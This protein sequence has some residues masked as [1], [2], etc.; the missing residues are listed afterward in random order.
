LI[1]LTE[2]FEEL[3][4]LLTGVVLHS[5]WIIGSPQ[6]I[7]DM[8]CLKI[9]IDGREDRTSTS[10]AKKSQSYRDATAPVTGKAIM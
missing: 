7:A 2:V 8:E 4:I 6:R 3:L 10:R 9:V 1:L 5:K